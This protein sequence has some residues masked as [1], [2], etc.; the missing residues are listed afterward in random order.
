MST[1]RVDDL[2]ST[3]AE[4]HRPL[5]LFEK[6]HGY[7]GTQLF[8]GL[9]ARIQMRSLVNLDL[10]KTSLVK[11]KRMPSFNWRNIQ[12]DQEVFLNL[13]RVP[14]SHP[15]TVHEYRRPIP[16]SLDTVG[17]RDASYLGQAYYCPSK[18]LKVKICV[19]IPP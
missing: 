4:Y 18:I 3:F 13:P 2:Q 12:F 14:W 16:H 5:A 9:I 10:F 15:Y 17:R 11:A 8:L 19:Q 6:K 1:K 7:I